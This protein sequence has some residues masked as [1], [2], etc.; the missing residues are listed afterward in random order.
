MT[1]TGWYLLVGLIL[2]SMGLTASKVR[3]LPLTSAICY[4]IVG[5][6]VGPTVL[7]LF[8]FNPLHQSAVLE[9]ITEIAVI[10]SLFTAGLKIQTPLRDSIWLAP[11]RLA[12]VSMAISVAMVALLGHY[13][14]DMPW[15]LAVLMGA[16]LAPTDPVL[17]TDVQLKNPR[18]KDPLRFSLTTEAG[19][20]DGSAFP[21]VML[22]LGLLG[23]HEIGPNAIDWFIYDLFWAT[24][25]G[26]AIGALMG[27]LLAH[28]IVWI[29]RHEGETEFMDD[30]L[31][32]GL[33]ALSYGVA[34]W[35]QTYA[36]LAVFAAA[37]ALRQTEQRLMSVKPNSATLASYSDP[38]LIGSEGKH[39]GSGKKALMSNRSLGF[40]EQLERISE[41]LLIIL[42]GGMLFVNSWTY[43]AVGVA[44]FLFFVV[45]P[46]STWLGLFRSNLYRDTRGYIAWFGVRGIGSM[47]YLMYVIQ[48]GL[49]DE[50]ALRLLSI[51]LIVI[52]LSIV[53]HGISVTPLMGRYQLLRKLAKLRRKQKT[54]PEP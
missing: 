14:L 31:G 12:F 29:R 21:F 2:L 48:H 9:I 10:I 28:V 47:Y 53:L 24:L 17:A 3:Q 1:I 36:F 4:L 18:D 39:R 49:P 51:T 8:H 35:A 19:L 11:I 27:L 15:G 43:E 16:I 7:G 5:L 32:L 22:G 23:L 52:T 44:L 34:L 46:V 6:V 30:F 42:I 38:K 25:G 45:R 13:I 37:V 20:N 33:L 41:V 26:L 40:N 50:Q 54:A